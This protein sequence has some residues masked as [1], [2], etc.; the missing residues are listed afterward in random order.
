MKTI[1]CFPG[2]GRET[3]WCPHTSRGQSTQHS[4]LHPGLMP[5]LV[6]RSVII[7][8][9]PIKIQSNPGSTA[10]EEEG[11]LVDSHV[12]YR[13]ALQCMTDTCLPPCHTA[14][15]EDVTQGPAGHVDSL[16]WE[17]PQC[18][19]MWWSDGRETWSSLSVMKRHGS[20][21]SR[22]EG[23]ACCERADSPPGAMLRS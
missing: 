4:L 5:G 13:P 2:N 11:R 14:Q 12:T 22:V 19:S 15:M 6:A 9:G 10:W 7:C 17:P 8:L 1:A 23:G 16:Q 21:D 18:S 20:G 3:P